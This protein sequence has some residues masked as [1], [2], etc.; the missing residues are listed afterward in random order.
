[1]YILMQYVNCNIFISG[2]AYNKLE[3]RSNELILTMYEKM[4][5]KNRPNKTMDFQ[6]T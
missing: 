3:S 6:R 4:V 2:C 5:F 1:M